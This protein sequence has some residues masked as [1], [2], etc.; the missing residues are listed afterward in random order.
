MRQ[1]VRPESGQS[2][3]FKLV[4]TSTFEKTG[5]LRKH[6][7]NIADLWTQIKVCVF[8]DTGQEYCHF[9]LTF[10]ITYYYSYHGRL[11]K[12]KTVLLILYEH[13]ELCSFV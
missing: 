10:G 8:P 12:S 5:K 11:H 13:K 3:I 1:N 2:V 4:S 9:A 7:A 6:A